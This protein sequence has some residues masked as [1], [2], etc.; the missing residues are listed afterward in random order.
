MLSV[1]FDDIRYSIIIERAVGRQA[2][3]HISGSG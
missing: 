1:L 2:D 3:G